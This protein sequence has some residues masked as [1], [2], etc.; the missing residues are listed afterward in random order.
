MIPGRV[1]PL[2][3]HAADGQP[4]G[5]LHRVPERPARGVA[6]LLHAMMVD[7]RSLLRGLPEV[8][9]AAGWHVV[10][11]DFRG[12]KLSPRAVPWRYDDLVRLDLPALIHG[13]RR[14]IPGPPVF[15]VGHSLGG[16]VSMAAASEM[17]EPAQGHVGLAANIWLPSLEPGRRRRAAKGVAMRGFRQISR[18]AGRFPS[19]RV[20]MGPVDEALPYVEDLVGFWTAD[21]WASHDGVDWLAGMSRVSGPYLSV[22]GAGDR[23][24]GHPV[25]ARRWAEHHPRAEVRVFGARE[26]GFAPGHMEIVTDARSRPIWDEIAAWMSARV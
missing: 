3:F 11:A 24:M 15:V 17:G 12:R 1:Q 21:R 20:R 26:V 18:A 16:H 7:H 2:S 9:A 13:V 10:L 6:L 19:R 23:L 14:A 4:L 25:A 8:L 5:A 22:L